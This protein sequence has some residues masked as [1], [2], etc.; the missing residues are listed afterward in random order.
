MSLELSIADQ[1][2]LQAAETRAVMNALVDARF[3][4][5]C[6]RN[7]LLGLK[8]DDID[9]ATPLTPEEVSSRVEA[10]GMRA[11]ATGLE[12]GTLTIICNSRPFE[13]TTLRRDVSTDGR[14]A[15][16]AFT[17]DWAEDAARRDFTI[18]ALYADAAGKVFDYQ[19][20]LADLKAGRVRFI[21]DA[22]VR[23]AEDYLR[24]LRL[25]RIHAWYG[26]GAIDAVALQACQAARGLLSNLSGERIQREMLKLFCAPDPLP[27]LQAM[28]DGGVL[29]ALVP[30]SLQ[31]KRFETMCANDKALAWGSDGL[32]RLGSLILEPAIARSVASRWRLSNE[33][34]DR[35]TGMHDTQINVSATTPLQEIEKVLYRIGVTTFCDVI[36]LRWAE[37]TN[38]RDEQDWVR[39]LRLARQW[40]RPQFPISGTDIMSK[41]VAHGP[42]VGRVL[43]HIEGWWVENGF[44]DDAGLLAGQVDAAIASLN[45]AH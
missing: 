26:R 33:D 10:Q 14:R 28:H 17:K 1:P 40:R 4:G 41:G 42:E 19:H 23:I 31:L 7:A 22:N 13:V 27:A 21:G 34:R 38:G 45:S 44:P 8:V 2:W 11:V 24:V 6:V 12:H 36:R 35:L 37:Q 20:G 3:V 16:I 30:G 39:L 15:S 25:F 29:A 5:G 32:L 43:R 18:N 9:I